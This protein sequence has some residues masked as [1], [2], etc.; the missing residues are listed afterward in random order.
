MLANLQVLAENGA[1]CLGLAENWPLVKEWLCGAFV[2]VDTQPSP[3]TLCVRNVSV[4]HQIDELRSVFDDSM[5][6]LG[7]GVL[8]HLLNSRSAQSSEAEETLKLLL[9][10]GLDPDVADGDGCRPLHLVARNRTYRLGSLLLLCRPDVNAVD[11]S[12]QK[13]FDVIENQYKVRTEKHVKY[14]SSTEIPFKNAG[15]FAL[16]QGSACQPLYATQ[17]LVS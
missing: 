14:F 17:L 2:Q 10:L 6:K 8:A 15:K 16:L 9:S 12:G 7:N 4:Q 1:F 13:P 5:D 11:G 3:A